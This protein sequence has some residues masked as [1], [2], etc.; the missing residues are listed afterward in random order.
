MSFT[1]F[2]G[3]TAYF[4][5][6]TSSFIVKIWQ[7]YGGEVG[8]FSLSNNIVFLIST[9]K[10]NA[11]H[12]RWIYDSILL[13][14]RLPF[15]D[16]YA[17]NQP[18]LI[19]L[20]SLYKQLKQKKLKK[21]SDHS[22][23]ISQKDLDVHVSDGFLSTPIQSHSFNDTTLSDKSVNPFHSTP[24]KIT[25]LSSSS[26]KHFNLLSS[27][28]QKIETLDFDRSLNNTSFSYTKK[29]S[30]VSSS[31]ETPSSPIERSK[32]LDLEDL[33][34][35]VDIF[36]VI[37]VE[38]MHGENGIL[39]LKLNNLVSSYILFILNILNYLSN[40]RLGKKVR[41]KCNEDDTVGD[42]KKLIAA[43]TGTNW[44]KIVLKKWYNTFKDHI[45]LSDYEIHK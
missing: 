22:K 2:E 36:E 26:D 6:R 31:I 12:E 37:A 29:T 28:Y 9:R 34:S 42:L 30:S 15:D 13:R 5:K 23:N 19:K 17:M 39:F 27:S 14:K 40:D 1:L 41:V 16:Y 4:S 43:Q 38:K 45:T 44:Q 33:E 8:T 32:V 18:R 7:V 21:T 24:E 25:Y 10:K 11:L 3:L 20:K 35:A